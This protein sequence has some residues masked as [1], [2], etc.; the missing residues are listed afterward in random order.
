MLVVHMIYQIKDNYFYFYD[1][2]QNYAF[3]QTLNISNKTDI[4]QI[5]SKG[6]YLII[7]SDSKNMLNNYVFDYLYKYNHESREFIFIKE[8]V[9]YLSL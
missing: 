4:F 8:E 5:Y 3:I 7:M 6:S 1:M 9:R 2:N